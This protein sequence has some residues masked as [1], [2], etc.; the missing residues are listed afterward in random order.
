[1]MLMISWGR[2]SDRIGRKPVLVLSLVGVSIATSIFGLSKTIW[3]MILFRCCAGMFAGT[4]VWV[5]EVVQYKLVVNGP[6]RTIRTMLSEHSTPK[7]QARAFSFFA[8]SGNVGIF[9]GPLVGMSTY[10]IQ[11]KTLLALTWCRGRSCWPS[12]KYRWLL[13]EDTVLPWISVLTCDF[14]HGFNWCKCRYCLCTIHQGGLYTTW[15]LSTM[16]NADAF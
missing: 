16:P 11:L 9:L 3:Q 12:E 2:A 7:T 5:L 8:F 10:G 15:P 1:M 14:F 6:C 13:Q 4:I